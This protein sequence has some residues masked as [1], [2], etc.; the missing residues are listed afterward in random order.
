MTPPI[1]S[2]SGLVTRIKLSN[3]NIAE[4]RLPQDG[5]F[6]LN[7]RK[8]IWTFVFQFYQLY[9]EKKLLCAYWIKQDLILTFH[10]EFS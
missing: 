10:P 4:K 5:R 2:L 6:Q 9:M 8:K 1:A 3:L 7:L